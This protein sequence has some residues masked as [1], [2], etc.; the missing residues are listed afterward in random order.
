MDTSSPLRACGSPTP[1]H[2][3][4]SKFSTVMAPAS[5]DHAPPDQAIHV[6]AALARDVPV[7]AT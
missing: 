3:T 5:F 4:G 2:R 7:L 6:T 1:H